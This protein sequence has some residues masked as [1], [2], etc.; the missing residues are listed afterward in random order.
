MNLVINY[1]DVQIH[2]TKHNEYKMHL[3][4]HYLDGG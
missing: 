3:Y 4:F 1:V 2:Q